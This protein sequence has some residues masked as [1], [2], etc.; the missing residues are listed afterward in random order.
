[1]IMCGRFELKADKE[2]LEKIFEKGKKRLNPDF[3]YNIEM[4]LENIAPTDPIY[5]I[6][7][8]NSGYNLAQTRWG[9]KF[10]DTAPLIFNSRIE[11]IKEKQY[12]KTLFMNSRCLIPMTAF[13]EWIKVGTKKIPQ[14]IFLHETELFFAPA[15]YDRDRNILCSSIITTAP[16]KFMIP[17]HNR[18]PVLL[19]FD[20]GIKYLHNDY[21][22]NLKLCMPYSDELKM[23]IEQATI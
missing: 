5:S 16:N 18:M 20:D 13:Y 6:I 11:T 3:D 22:S 21:E 19:N 8:R 1:M 12:W 4:K 7:Y 17:I 2:Y 15:I 14:R 9:F 10:S 23:G